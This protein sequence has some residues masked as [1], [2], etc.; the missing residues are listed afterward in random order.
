MHHS[1]EDL[2]DKLQGIVNTTNKAREFNQN[3]YYSA[4]AAADIKEELQQSNKLLK[5]GLQKV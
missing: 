2:R 4:G 1:Q 5:L 3:T